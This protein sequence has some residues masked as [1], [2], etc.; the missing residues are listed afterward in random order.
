MLAN[1][2]EVCDL[3]LAYNLVKAA[4]HL[5]FYCVSYGF[6]LWARWVHI[7]TLNP[8]IWNYFLLY[9]IVWPLYHLC[10]AFELFFLS[11]FIYLIFW[12][13]E[14]SEITNYDYTS[15][16]KSCFLTKLMGPTNVELLFDTRFIPLIMGLAF[17]YIANTS[18]SM[19]LPF[20]LEVRR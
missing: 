11:L 1:D 13:L 17:V 6:Q 18:F 4:V 19:L 7:W 8:W 15:T 5:M 3:I 9:S 12:F 20:Y 2:K 14:Y 10:I 16:K